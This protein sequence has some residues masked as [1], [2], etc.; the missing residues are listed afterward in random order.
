MPTTHEFLR[1]FT[2]KSPEQQKIVKKNAKKVKF[3]I[4]CPIDFSKSD[5]YQTIGSQVLL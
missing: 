2:K 4:F 1:K 5:S 3:H